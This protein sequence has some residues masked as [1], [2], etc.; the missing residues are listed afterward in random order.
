MN[1]WPRL[2]SEQRVLAATPPDD[3]CARSS[4]RHLHRTRPD[5]SF[6]LLLQEAWPFIEKERRVDILRSA[7]RLRAAL[8]GLYAAL[9]VGATADLHRGFVD[10]F[11]TIDAPL[12]RLLWTSGNSQPT[13]STVY[14]KARPKAQRA[15]EADVDSDRPLS[16]VPWKLTRKEMLALHLIRLGLSNKGIAREMQVTPETV[17][18][19]IKRIFV[20]L[21][22]RNRAEAVS[23][24]VE[25]GLL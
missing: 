4:P 24:A 15:L 19:H 16:N 13:Q 9:Q 1:A 2:V 25:L 22:A 10:H 11:L 12:R 14:P 8:Q 17:K 23:R 3:V 6:E 18:S 20:K 7:S 5:F 21:S